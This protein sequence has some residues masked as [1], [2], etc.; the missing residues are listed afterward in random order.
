MTQLGGQANSMGIISVIAGPLS[1]VCCL[2]T[3]FGGGAAYLFTLILAIPAIVLGI[4]HL[5]RV[6]AGQ[7]SNKNL[8]IIGIAFGVLGLIIAICG[9]TTSAGGGFHRNIN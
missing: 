7:A 3:A 1:V 2:C 4:L 9:A 6:S 5:R 8:A